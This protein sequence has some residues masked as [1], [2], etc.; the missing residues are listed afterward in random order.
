MYNANE[1]EPHIAMQ[2]IDR[3]LRLAISPDTA[4][5]IFEKEGK[6]DKED[7]VEDND[8]FDDDYDDKPETILWNGPLRKDPL[9]WGGMGGQQQPRQFIGQGFGHH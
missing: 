2:L 5:T 4:R 9:P 1:L 6:D 3:L 8:D 7:P